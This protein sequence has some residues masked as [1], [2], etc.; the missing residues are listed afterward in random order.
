[1]PGNPQE[2]AEFEQHA[3]PLSR[4]SLSA[5]LPSLHLHLPSK[6]FLQ[7]LYNRYITAG[8]KAVCLQ[9]FSTVLLVSPRAHDSLP[10]MRSSMQLLTSRY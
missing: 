3:S 7:T 1:M 10:V 5:S 4:L 9:G 6:T 8:W 2:M